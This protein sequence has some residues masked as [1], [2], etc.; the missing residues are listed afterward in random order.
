MSFPNIQL[1]EAELLLQA[2]DQALYQAKAK[3]RNRVIVD[4]SLDQS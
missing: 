2:A 3:G 1:M 4:L